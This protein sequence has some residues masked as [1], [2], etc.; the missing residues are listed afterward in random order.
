MVPAYFELKIYLGIINLYAVLLY[1]LL[2]FK[3][4]NQKEPCQFNIL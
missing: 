2:G 4:H 1:M 3:N